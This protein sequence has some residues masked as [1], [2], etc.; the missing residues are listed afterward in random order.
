MLSESF[1]KR[2]ESF[3]IS[4]S[5]KQHYKQVGYIRDADSTRKYLNYFKHTSL[6]LFL[7]TTKE[8]KINTDNVVSLAPDHY[9][10]QFPSP[11]YPVPIFEEDYKKDIP[12]HKAK[13]H[14]FPY[15]IKKRKSRSSRALMYFHGWG[16]G[17]FGVEKQFQFK[18][19]QK[20]YKTDIFA[21][22][23]PY[24][25]T[26]NPKPLTTFSGQGFLDSDV[27]RTIEAFRQGTIESYYLY[28]FLHGIY[29][30]VGA[31]GVSL[32]AHILTMLN[33]LIDHNMFSLTC[34]V[35]SPMK[36]NIRNLKISPNML[37]SIK[38]REVIQAMSILD[39][40]K[41]EI[42][43]YNE[44]QYLFGGRFDSIIAPHTVKKLGKHMKSKTFIVPTG[45]FTFP[46]YLPIIVN[47]I[48]RWPKNK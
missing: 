46:L 12:L 33:L 40:N 36:D 3:I 2:A 47:R 7:P 9:V 37:H 39:F 24:H 20:A 43:H 13:L 21:I 18:L 35:G 4:L 34:L 19:L 42:K 25:H 1:L 15:N 30:E 45:H 44:H 41:I 14:Y 26:R 29:P 31:V 48:A 38:N 32:G 17:S 16:R 6:K 27:V 11:Y 22:E 23:L 8:F 28:K 10:I 5:I